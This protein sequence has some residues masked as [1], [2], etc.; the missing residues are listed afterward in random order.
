LGRR[1][2]SHPPLRSHLIDRVDPDFFSS[3]LATAQCSSDSSDWLTVDIDLPEVARRSD[4]V[5]MRPSFSLT[6][7]TLPASGTAFRDYNDRD[8]VQA[9][10]VRF[11]LE[12]LVL[13]E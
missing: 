11:G 5:A 12:M 4:C 10:G 13:R 8:E 9:E 3:L 6:R 2:A 1:F 7:R